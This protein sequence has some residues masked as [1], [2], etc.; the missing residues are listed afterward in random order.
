M[1]HVLQITLV[2]GGVGAAGLAALYVWAQQLHHSLV[3][4]VKHKSVTT[5]ELKGM[6]DR[7]ELE[8]LSPHL[9]RDLEDYKIIYDID[10]RSSNSVAFP[11]RERLDKLFTQ[12]LRRNMS[13]FARFPQSWTLWLI[14][15][16]PE[17]RESFSQAHIKA[18]NFREDDVF[19]GFYRVVKRTSGRVEIGMAIPA[20]QPPIEG[21]LIISLREQE[22]G[23]AMRTETLQWT[24]ARSGAVL[25]LDRRPIRFMHEVA[26]WWLLVTGVEYLEKIS[27][28]I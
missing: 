26:S 28:E 7:G 4:Q 18:L 17:Q 22:G 5:K 23:T 13:L 16:S 2:G 12:L 11:A 14:A 9:T 27:S 15:K 8:T 21:R 19:C 1:D 20:Q 6:R 10:E 24:E 3:Q 25:P